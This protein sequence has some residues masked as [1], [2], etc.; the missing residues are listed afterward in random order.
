MALKKCVFIL[1]CV[2]LFSLLIAVKADDD[3]EQHETQD[4]SGNDMR[5]DILRPL[6]ACVHR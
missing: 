6:H 4:S 3:G 5:A 1:S 2:C